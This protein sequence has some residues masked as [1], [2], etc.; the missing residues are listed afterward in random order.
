MVAVALYSGLRNRVAP[1]ACRGAHAGSTASISHLYRRSAEMYRPQ[2]IPGSGRGGAAARLPH[3]AEVRLAGNGDGGVV[4]P[5]GYWL[6]LAGGHR[7]GTPLKL[8]GRMGEAH[9]Q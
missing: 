6:D 8:R 7:C 1:D 4:L 2:G 3:G 5:W 9:A